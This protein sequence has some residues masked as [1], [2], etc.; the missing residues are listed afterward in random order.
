MP[1]LKVSCEFEG[2]P[3]DLFC[4]TQLLTKTFSAG[5]FERLKP[6]SP[7]TL[8]IISDEQPEE[9]SELQRLHATHI[10]EF[11]L[12][13]QVYQKLWRSDIETVGDVL[14]KTRRELLSIWNFGDKYLQELVAAFGLRGL[15]IKP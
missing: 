13:P 5:S 15:Y 12:Q 14:L 4:A 10:S 2:D 9:L 11:G 3:Y 7:L 1:I 6:R 8:Q